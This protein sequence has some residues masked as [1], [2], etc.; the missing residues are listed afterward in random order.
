MI[1]KN[2]GEQPN[3]FAKSMKI[4]LIAV[5]TKMPSWVTQGYHEYA[6]RLPKAFSLQLIEIPAQKRDKGVD[7]K[8]LLHLE[9]EHLFSAVPNH[10]KIIVLDR[11][12]QPL[13]T[14]AFAEKFIE[15]QKDSQDI[16]ILIGGPEGISA[17]FIQKAHASWSL[18]ALTLPHP[19]IRVVIAEQI[20]RAWS[21]IHHHPY[22]R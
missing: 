18:S 8:R 4:N 5:G 7:M 11:L 9:S 13:T 3:G 15:F 21:L 14:R 19:L 6:Q 17:F 12:G 22:H 16:S 10:N 2:F 20:Y 1:W